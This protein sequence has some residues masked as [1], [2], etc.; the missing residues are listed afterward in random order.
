[1][2]LQLATLSATKFLVVIRYILVVKDFCRLKFLVA[3]LVV[4]RQK[5]WR[6]N[7]FSRRK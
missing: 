4:D 3:R 1:M 6:L 5:N 7:F 2:S